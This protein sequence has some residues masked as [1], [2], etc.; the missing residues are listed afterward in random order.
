M[1]SKNIT[2]QYYKKKVVSIFNWMN[3]VPNYFILF[4][5]LFS[6]LTTQTYAI[7]IDD[8]DA[9][10]RKLFG[11]TIIKT[12]DA[13]AF[14]GLALTRI[15][16]LNSFLG[17]NRDSNF[18]INIEPESKSKA[19]VILNI[20]TLP[21]FKYKKLKSNFENTINIK[22]KKITVFTPKTNIANEVAKFKK[23]EQI[24]IDWVPIAFRVL[25]KEFNKR[26]TALENRKPQIIREYVTNTPIHNHNVSL[27]QRIDRL[28]NVSL[29]SPVLYDATGKFTVLNVDNLNVGTLS[30]TKTLSDSTGSVGNYGQML[31]STGTSTKWVDPASLALGSIDQHTDVDTSTSPPTS[32]QALIWDGVNWVPQTIVQNNIYTS[33]GVL[34]SDRN[35]TQNGNNLSVDNNKLFIKG[36]SSVRVGIGTINPSSPLV[37]D[38]N[39][40]IFEFDTSNYSEPEF[41]MTT[42]NNKRA[43][44][45]FR[46]TGAGEAAIRFT[47]LADVNKNWAIGIQ[48]SD[49]AFRIKQGFDGTGRLADYKNEYFT[50][51][52]GGNVGIST[53]TPQFKL[54]V[55]GDVNIASGFK[56]KIDGNNLAIDHL[57]DGFTN[58]L[59]MFLGDRSNTSVVGGGHIGIG[60]YALSSLSGGLYNTAVG[61]ESLQNL[62][63]G[64]YNVAVGRGALFSAKGSDNTVVGSEAMYNLFNGE[65]NTALGRE[66][67]R[68]AGGNNNIFIGYRAGRNTGINASNNIVIG[69]NIDL[70]DTDAS[71]QL[72]IGNLIFGTG[73]DGT[74][75]SISSGR[76]GIATTT[77]SA[78]LDV[79]GT[80]NIGD[81]Y[82]GV[83]GVYNF[84]VNGPGAGIFLNR[85][86][87]NPNAEAF[88]RVTN[89]YG[90]GGQIRALSAGGFR[91][92]NNTSLI[93]YLRMDANGNIGIGSNSPTDKLH[94]VGNLRV[95][96]AYKDSSNS[97]GLSGQVLTSTG[98]GTQWTNANSLGV[99]TIYTADGSLTS[100]RSVNLNGNNLLFT[101][102]GNIGIGT[103]SPV[104]KLQVNG[105]VRATRF[106]AASGTAGSPAFRYDAD[107]DTGLFNPAANTLAITTA[108]VERLRVNNLGNIGIGVQNPLAKLHLEGGEI[109]MFN[110]NNNPRFIIGDSAYT[111]QYGWMQWDSTND[112]F[113]IDTSDS[114]SLGVKIKG[115]TLAIGN[116]FPD[117]NK[118]FIASDN[119]NVKLVINKTGEVGI[120]TSTPQEMLHVEGGRIKLLNSGP[121]NNGILNG[122][123]L[124]FNNGNYGYIQTYDNRPLYINYLGNNT[125][126]NVNSSNVGIG[127]TSPSEK[128]DVSGR[129]QVAN[130]GN[131][132]P[133]GIGLVFGHNGSY[134]YLQSYQGTPLYVNSLG[135]NTIINPNSGKVGIGVSIPLEKLDVSGV[136]RAGDNLSTNGSMILGGAY[137]NGYLT[138]LGS[139]YSSGAPVLAYG[140]KPKSGALGYV[141]S[142]GVTLTRSA[143]KL[144]DGLH[145]LTAPSQ[146]VAIGTDVAMSEILTVTNNGNVG[147][148]INA[149]TEKLHIQGSMRITGALKD[150]TNS[151]G[152]TGQVLVSTGTGV[153][154]QNPISCIIGGAKVQGNGT[155]I[156]SYGIVSGVTRTNTGR[157]TV[158][159]ASTLNTSDY[160]AHVSK[161]ESTGTRDDVN[162][163]VSVYNT[164]NVQVIIH[165]GDNGTSAN[166]YRDR[167]FSITLFDANCT[168]LSPL[169][170]SDRRLKTNIRNI[171]S[172]EALEKVLQLQGVRYNWNTE[173][174]PYRR[175]AGFDD[176]PE[177]GL[178][179]QDV[180]KVVPELVD[181]AGDGY[182]TL[183][184]G[185]LTSLLVE[186]IKD[187]WIKITG[188][189]EKVQKIDELER[190]VKALEDA[191]NNSYQS[192]RQTGSQNTSSSGNLGISEA[193]EPGNQ[194]RKSEKEH[195]ENIQEANTQESDYYKDVG[196]VNTE[197]SETGNDNGDN[198]TNIQNYEANTNEGGSQEESNKANLKD[199][200]ASGDIINNGN[201][202][203]DGSFV[204]ETNINIDNNSLNSLDEQQDSS[205]SSGE[206]DVNHENSTDS[207]NLVSSE[208]DHLE[209]NL[210]N[211][212][213]QE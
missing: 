128:L 149:P 125:I 78:T 191:L 69:Y 74:G 10:T 176:K 25:S 84:V 148:G 181:K 200:Q 167:N 83:S 2:R 133:G 129:I 145:F 91:F 80:V 95:T 143:L 164:N 106:V 123:Y 22:S 26:L 38:D 40:T 183:D 97:A 211:T 193:I 11:V 158:N 199:K 56:Y 127:T 120:G 19:K 171:D 136:V 34:S 192:G 195:D 1:F 30:L 177:I 185:K 72:N 209:S 24:N 126:F 135:N 61:V 100:L 89:N 207:N 184:Y 48:D 163:D 12:E 144:D 204:D 130:S 122:M 60:Y 178:I 137:I 90:G 203:D 212:E 105:N 7:Q 165:E 46:Y 3:K 108:G 132:N 112:Y 102:V 73:I 131:P 31:M 150:S 196:S 87:T 62:Q 162:I 86:G 51:L 208:D 119:S 43:S 82:P 107:T 151:A 103:A 189:E 170:N 104:N 141:S 96:G 166:V 53:S 85:N 39:G 92:T 110:S 139:F 111:G 52:P 182:L 201:S 49:N 117:P 154:W 64:S 98:S 147:I 160:Y 186:A 5:L 153:K 77:P 21:T 54:D 57:E 109:W 15:F 50:V 23:T 124:G 58:G 44:F 134:G 169:A 115:N 155:V 37:I 113:R 81:E 67:G 55:N 13:L 152:T 16:D 146:T 205:Q 65:R 8:V 36:G 140:V 121:I 101:G 79:Y 142:T 27:S 35:I 66:A 29:Y 17:I 20:K 70:P 14:A 197:E 33:D 118:L 210:S 71:N 157:Y 88:I 59:S 9:Q 75:Q 114:P 47:K 213:E 190:R 161:E 194:Q 68:Y 172:H 99:D 168:A 156:N 174:Y 6:V 94:V 45:A 202:S 76:I 32:G 180:Q 159:F 93:E 42:S 179:A 187:L 173:K 4:I 63:N 206:S 198:S 28:Y 188:I 175:V 116:I 18:A 138:T 41:R